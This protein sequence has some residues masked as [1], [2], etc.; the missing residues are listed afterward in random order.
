VN[1][2]IT[3]GNI[4]FDTDKHQVVGDRNYE[5]SNHLGN[6][7]QVITDRKL[8]VETAPESGIVDYYVADVVS[9]SDYYPFGMVMPNRNEDDGS[10]YRYSFQGQ[11]KDDEIKGD[12][13]SVNYKYRMHDPRVGRFFAVDPLATSYPW[14]SPY[15]FSENKVIYAIELEGLEA[16]NATAM[17]FDGKFGGIGGVKILG[18]NVTVVY[19][20]DESTATYMMTIS[21][22]FNGK[23]E[24][25][26]FDHNP[27]L[28]GG[29]G[30]TYQEKIDLANSIGWYDAATVDNIKSIMTPDKEDAFVNAFA[31]KFT[32][33]VG[34]DSELNDNFS[35]SYGNT[36]R[37]LTMSALLAIYI[38]E[39]NIQEVTDFNERTHIANYGFD[40]DTFTDLVNNFYGK[41]YAQDNGISPEDVNTAEGMADFLNGLT[42]Y[43]INSFDE[44]KNDPNLKDYKDG[45]KNMWNKDDEIVKKLASDI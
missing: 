23:K 2:G 13:N 12:G 27:L 35:S 15:A 5:L 6:V 44:L 33:I 3:S 26:E 30:G 43:M 19:D 17:T 36:L 18:S 25:F 28:P 8:A 29:K 42:R 40:S 7:L 41:K 22:T 16:A 1:V 24:T 45:T 14:N 21:H 11:E 32:A 4:N 37:H 34:E 38:D 20:V 10:S 9:Q 39:D 31:E